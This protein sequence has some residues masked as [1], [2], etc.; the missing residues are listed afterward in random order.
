MSDVKCP[1]CGKPNPADAEVCE[2][3]QARLK[4]LIVGDSGSSDPADLLAGLRL[5]GETNSAD[6]DAPEPEASEV[7]STDWLARIR[8]RHQ[9]ETPAPTEETPI[10]GEETVSDWLAGLRQEPEEPASEDDALSRLFGEAAPTAPESVPATPSPETIPG[11]G[12]PVNELTPQT[13]LAGSEDDL[14]WLNAFQAVGSADSEKTSEEPT[15]ETPSGPIEAEPA[16]DLD[17]LADFGTREQP[18]SEAKSD[19]DLGWLSAFQGED[20]T[21]SG[22]SPLEPVADAPFTPIESATEPTT[23]FGLGADLSSGEKPAAEAGSDDD[24]GWLSAFQAEG[25]TGSEIPPIEPVAEPP[26]EAV[27]S[28]SEPAPNFGFQADLGSNELNTAEARQD[29]DSR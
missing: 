14:G 10:G 9:A 23:D 2:Y 1:M 24:L 25:P 29:D 18:V 11:G 13:P 27:E 3:C 16:A 5:T 17:W 6:S 12:E 15:A 19:D 26:L 7:D 8:A 28:I 21:G 20:L 4:P 22:T